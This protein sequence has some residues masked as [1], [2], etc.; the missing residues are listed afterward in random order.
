VSVPNPVQP[1]QP[2]IVIVH[3]QDPQQQE[4]LHRLRMQERCV[5]CCCLTIVFWW[6]GA[7]ILEFAF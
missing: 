6:I 4:Q 2:E 1:V 3:V 7:V 5:G